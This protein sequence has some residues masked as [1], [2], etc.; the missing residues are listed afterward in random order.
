MQ[1]AHGRAFLVCGTPTQGY[2]L[3]LGSSQAANT[4]RAFDPMLERA[5]ENQPQ[6][7]LNEPHISSLAAS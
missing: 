6:P 3:I 7:L 1:D 4:P 2:A 5:A